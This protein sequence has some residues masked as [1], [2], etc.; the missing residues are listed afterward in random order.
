MAR[1]VKQSGDVDSPDTELPVATAATTPLPEPA[2]EQVETRTL[3]DRLAG[4]IGR[5]RSGRSDLSE[6]ASELFGEG[7]LEK[8]REGRL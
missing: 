2:G 6:R 8:K 1:D 3:A 4:R 7:L 5:I